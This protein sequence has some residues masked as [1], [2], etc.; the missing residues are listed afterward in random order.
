M[1][2]GTLLVSYHLRIHNHISKTDASNE[3]D[4]SLI[5]NEKLVGDQS[6]LRIEKKDNHLGAGPQSP[7]G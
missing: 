2:K 7:A 1:I 6:S 5:K 4:L 3:P